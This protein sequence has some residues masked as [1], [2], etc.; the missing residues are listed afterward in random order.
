M[1]G[2]SSYTLTAAIRTDAVSGNARVMAIESGGTT[3]T[4]AT[5][6]GT[7]AWTVYST[8]FVTQPT[9]TSIT[10]RLQVD[11]SG[12]ASFDD[13]SL[14]ITPTVALMLSASVCRLRRRRSAVLA[15]HAQPG[16]DRDGHVEHD[17]GALAAGCGQLHRRHRQDVPAGAAGL[18]AD[19]R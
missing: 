1:V 15:V 17:L 12:R 18:A 2:D 11:G 19:R 4:L 8:T 16:A 6:T 5:V 7:S 9:T 10:V 3:T 13:V 14:A